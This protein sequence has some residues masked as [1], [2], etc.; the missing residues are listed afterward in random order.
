[1]QCNRRCPKLLLISV[2]FVVVVNTACEGTVCPL[3]SGFAILG[4]AGLLIIR[5][6]EAGLAPEA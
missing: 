1:M 6:T 2:V 4:L 3:V 5:W